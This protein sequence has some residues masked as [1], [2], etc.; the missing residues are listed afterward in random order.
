MVSICVGIQWP[1][2]RWSPNLESERSREIEGCGLSSV[3]WGHAD[4]SAE[5]SR[6]GSD[7]YK[8]IHTTLDELIIED[9]QV[10]Q[11]KF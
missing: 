2:L 11:E 1:L 7:H 3:E 8:S 5:Q 9:D 10:Q 4:W 6:R